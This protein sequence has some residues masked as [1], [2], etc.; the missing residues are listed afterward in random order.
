MSIWV[1][2]FPSSDFRPK[3][4]VVSNLEKELAALKKNKSP[5]HH[6][7]ESRQRALPDIETKGCVADELGIQ[8]KAGEQSNRP[9]VPEDETESTLRATSKLES[10]QVE[11]VRQVG[12]VAS[13]TVPNIDSQRSVRQP[14]VSRKC[15]AKWRSREGHGGRREVERRD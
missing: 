10:S 3:A 9:L 13:V 15:W 11:I 8:V 7:L 14:L 1:D 12:L 4:Q 5:H 2:C 6:T